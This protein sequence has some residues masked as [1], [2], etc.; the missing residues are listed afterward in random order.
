MAY[1]KLM[2]FH[3]EIIHFELLPETPEDLQMKNLSF[4]VESKCVEMISVWFT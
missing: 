4:A 1:T 3:Q 2:A